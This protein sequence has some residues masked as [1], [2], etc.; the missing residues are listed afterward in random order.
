MSGQFYKRIAELIVGEIGGVLDVNEIHELE[1]W[2]QECSGNM[3]LYKRICNSARFSS[4]KNARNHFVPELKWNSFYN[5]LLRRKVRRLI[6]KYAVAF[7][8]VFILS[9]FQLK[10]ETTSETINFPN[11]ENQNKGQFS[12]MSDNEQS[13]AHSGNS[14]IKTPTVSYPSKSKGDKAVSGIIS[15]T[16]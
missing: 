5:K 3:E 11:Q 16:N 7:S 12:L 2:K 1:Q 13:I 9:N 6:S 8:F 14:P 10:S 4:W 15:L